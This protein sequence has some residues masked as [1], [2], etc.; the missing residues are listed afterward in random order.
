MDDE[1]KVELGSVFLEFDDGEA[2]PVKQETIGDEKTEYVVKGK[3]TR[4]SL[5]ELQ[6]RLDET[7]SIHLKD[8]D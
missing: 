3:T 5:D 4:I 1:K 8:N 7:Q 6:K 2:E